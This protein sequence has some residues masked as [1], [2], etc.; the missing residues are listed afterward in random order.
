MRRRDVS[1]VIRALYEEQPFA[2]KGDGRRFRSAEELDAHLDQVPPR[3]T[4]SWARRLSS[5]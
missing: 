2:C 3:P 4:L 5:D 1:D